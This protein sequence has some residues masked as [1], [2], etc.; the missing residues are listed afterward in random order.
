M[1]GRPEDPG[2][3]DPEK[4]L[5]LGRRVIPGRTLLPLIMVLFPLQLLLMIMLLD[6]MLLLL[7]GRMV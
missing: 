4:E 2:E 1:E 6:V 7:L 3:E 5:L